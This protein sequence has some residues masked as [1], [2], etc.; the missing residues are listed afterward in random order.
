MCMPKK[1]EIGTQSSHFD[2]LSL[3]EVP[4]RDDYVVKIQHEFLLK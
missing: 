3:E 1:A 4:K 2:I